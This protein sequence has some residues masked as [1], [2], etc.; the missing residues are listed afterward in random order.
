MLHIISYI[1]DM[2]KWNFIVKTRSSM[3]C[4]THV[5]NASMS[6]WKLSF[7]LPPWFNSDIHTKIWIFPDYSLGNNHWFEGKIDTNIQITLNCNWADIQFS[8]T[9]K[10][11]I[12]V[13][14]K[15]ME[16]TCIICEIGILHRSNMWKVYLNWNSLPML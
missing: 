16:K 5:W 11:S 7:A 14:S 15:Y 1:G 10:L 12:C 6:K 8:K 9:W 3:S 4:K 13:A 2:S